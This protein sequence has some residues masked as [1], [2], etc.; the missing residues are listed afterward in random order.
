MR[1]ERRRGVVPLDRLRLARHR[2]GEHL[3]HARDRNDLEALASRSVACTARRRSAVTGAPI[4]ARPHE[5]PAWRQRFSVS[6]RSEVRVAQ[7]A[8]MLMAL[9]GGWLE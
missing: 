8:D 9:L 5:R 6:M 4:S 7:F 3:V 1:G 2:A